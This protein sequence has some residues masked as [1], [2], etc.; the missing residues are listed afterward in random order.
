MPQERSGRAAGLPGR[1]AV[2][3]QHQSRFF[4]PHRASERE[5]ISPG[6]STTLPPSKGN[7]QMLGGANRR[8]NETG[9]FRRS[10]SRARAHV[11]RSGG[12]AKLTRDALLIATE[13]VR[14]KWWTALLGPLRLAVP[15]ATLLNYARGMASSRT[16]ARRVFE[17][18]R[19]RRRPFRFVMA[20]SVFG[21]EG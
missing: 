10:A 2:I 4:R 6:S 15:L 9:V 13:A 19:H 20:E 1:K 17:E 3:L 11:G 7:G 21:E 16:W 14:E 5:K 8:A 18:L 12:Y